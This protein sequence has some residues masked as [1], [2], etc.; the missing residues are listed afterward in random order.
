MSDIFDSHVS[1][2]MTILE[3]KLESSCFWVFSVFEI[4]DMT[5]SRYYSGFKTIDAGSERRP[6]RK[7]SST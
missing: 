3:I 4:V 5:Y 2:F 7:I 1:T 6:K